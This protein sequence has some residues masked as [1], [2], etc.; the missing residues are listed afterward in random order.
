[1]YVKKYLSLVLLYLSMS[2]ICSVVKKKKLFVSYFL[3]ISDKHLS[4]IFYI[5]V[6]KICCVFFYLLVRNVRLVFLY[7][8]DKYLVACFFYIYR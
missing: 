6:T 2:I 7:I 3:Y 8:N 5:L 4:H 1:M